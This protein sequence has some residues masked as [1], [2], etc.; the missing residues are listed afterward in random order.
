MKTR[1]L[2]ATG[3]ALVALGAMGMSQQAS[4]ITTNSDIQAIIVEPVSL[5]SVDDL[6]F[7]SIAAGTLGSDT[8]TI[9]PN[10][11]ART[12]G[13][14]DAVLIG[15]VGVDA[16]LNLDG[17]D[18]ATVTI[19]VPANG[20]VTVDFGPESMAVDDFTWSYNGGGATT[21]DG[22]AVLAVGGP[23]GLSIGATLTVGAGQAAGTYTG[24]FDVVVN[25][26]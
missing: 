2:F 16:L 4:A 10:T 1:I 23:H 14:G 20:T 13:A 15:A 7:G 26:Q 19:D 11:G 5:V 25:Y 6:D 18:G 12:K 3:T 21:G 8:V 22:T 9:A 17:A 24:N